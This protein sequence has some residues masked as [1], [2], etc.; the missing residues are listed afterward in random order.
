M[1]F[2]NR[3]FKK[4]EPVIYYRLEKLSEIWLNASCRSAENIDKDAL[5]DLEWE[6]AECQ[7]FWTDYVLANYRP[8]KASGFFPSIESILGILDNSQNVSSIDPEDKETP[9]KYRSLKG[10]TLRDHSLRVAQKCVD[11]LLSHHHDG[12][13]LV[14][15]AILAGLSHDIGKMFKDIPGADH[16]V[17]SA[18]WCQYKLSGMKG[19]E[20][21]IEAIRFHHA[22]NAQMP[23]K[24]AVLMALLKANEEARKEEL[25]RFEFESRQTAAA[26]IQAAT[27]Q[28]AKDAAQNTQPAAPVVEN[29]EAKE[30]AAATATEPEIEPYPCANPFGSDDKE[31]EPPAEA[32]SS[33]EAPPAASTDHLQQTQND[34]Q[35]PVAPKE[36]PVTEKL[37]KTAWLNEG[38]LLKRLTAKVTHIGFDAFVLDGKGFFAPKLI[39]TTLEEMA[40]EVGDAEFLSVLKQFVEPL[41]VGFGMENNQTRL[42]FGGKVPPQK[43]FYFIINASRLDLPEDYQPLNPRDDRR[44]LKSIKILEKEGSE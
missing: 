13:I 15:K 27:T 26:A 16:S 8:I 4:T 42:R 44:F 30:H 7:K 28:A 25:S 33:D 9:E 38:A 17:N 23:K 6:H 20:G 10:V 40:T 18:K 21:I 34:G 2:L 29:P 36:G 32:C 37:L 41:M 5:S 35:A 43:N 11:M 22:N 39:K 31:A 19:T 12:Q 14:A 24:N 1:L 3:L